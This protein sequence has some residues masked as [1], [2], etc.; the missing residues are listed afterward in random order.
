VARRQC[1]GSLCVL[2]VCQ[3]AGVM[4]GAIAHEQAQHLHAALDEVL[5]TS[6]SARAAF[7][8][9]VDVLESNADAVVFAADDTVTTQQA[10]A[11]LGVSR[12]TVVRLVDRGELAAVGGAVH[13]RIFA[14]E[15]ARY[16]AESSRRRRSA[17]AE[18]ADEIG[19]DT[20]PDQVIET[21]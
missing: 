8:R 3:Y 2:S 14:S 9:L 13:R 10:A 19:E 12:M 18:L 15:L 21:R 20:P 17:I 7:G 11:L 16:Q 4:A 1:N 5:R 6:P